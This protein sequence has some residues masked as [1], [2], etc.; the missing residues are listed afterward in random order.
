M[1][2]HDPRIT[3][4]VSMFRSFI[5]Q[6]MDD[7]KLVFYGKG[8]GMGHAESMAIEAGSKK[9]Q[10]AQPDRYTQGLPTPL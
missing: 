8:P 9:T 6:M 10:P 1:L 7:D 4:G 2:R 5:V 3:R